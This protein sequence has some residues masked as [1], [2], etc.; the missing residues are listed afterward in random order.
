MDG[1]SR[2]ASPFRSGRA[3]RNDH[4]AAASIAVD[5]DNFTRLKRN[6]ATRSG[7]TRAQGG[8]FAGKLPPQSH[9]LQ[10]VAWL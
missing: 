1:P 2:Q 4:L 9:S 7:T 8:R 6:L 3:A 10:N 5:L